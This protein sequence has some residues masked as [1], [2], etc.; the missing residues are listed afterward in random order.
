VVLFVNAD[1][2]VVVG[3]PGNEAL[4]PNV[5]IDDV[6]TL[7]ASVVP[8]S[9]PAAAVT[10]PDAPREID[11]PFTVTALLASFPLAID[12]ASMVFVTVPVSVVY[13]PLVTVAALPV[14]D[15]E[16][17]DTLPVTLPVNAPTNVVAVKA[18]VDALYPKEALYLGC[19]AVPEAALKN[20]GK[21]VVSDVSF[22]GCICCGVIAADPSKFTPP[23]A[24]GVVSVAAEPVVLWFSV[25]KVQ[26]VRAPDAGVPKIGATN[27]CCPDHVLA[28]PRARDATTA[29]VVGLM[30]SVPSE[31]ET[32]DT[33]PLPPVAVIVISPGDGLL[34]VIVI[35]EPSTRVTAPEMPST[36]VTPPEPGRKVVLLWTIG[37]P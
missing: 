20:A 36:V 35:P 26:L 28:L 23:I 33:A 8:V 37:I 7:L 3:L 14:V 32:D 24:R 1:C 10:V 34:S 5:V 15:P 2:V 11:V 22:A 31:F 4:V 12:P 25:G 6:I 13:T 21:H 19:C 17:P 9:V 18:F 30:V 27:V 16:D 29:P